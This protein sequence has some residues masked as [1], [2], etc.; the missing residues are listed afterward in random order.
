MKLE[1]QMRLAE[2][3]KRLRISRGLSQVRIAEDL[4]L[5]RSSLSLYESGRRTPD[6]EGLLQI[7]HYYGIQMEL[8][9]EADPNVIVSEVA[10][11]EICSGSEQE[12]LTIF[13]HL[14]PFSRGRLL[15]KAA[16]LADWD[17][18]RA[19]QQKALQNRIRE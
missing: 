5:D 3:L 7:A 8:L 9:L 10:C 1:T 14:T 17:N 18:Y 2:N 11:C 13:R 16:A 15:E 19:A 4:K 6:A 12:L